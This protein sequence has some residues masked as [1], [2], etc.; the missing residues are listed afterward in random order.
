MTD[1][2][3]RATEDEHDWLSAGYVDEWV[4]EWS[5]RVERPEELRR[6][7][8]ALPIER[9]A[10]MAVLDVGGGARVPRHGRVRQEPRRDPRNVVDG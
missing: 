7:A 9:N 8:V 5:N 1:D 10:P 3:V 2:R 4:A 6:V